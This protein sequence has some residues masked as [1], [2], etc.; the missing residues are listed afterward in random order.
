MQ[1]TPVSGGINNAYPSGQYDC[2]NAHYE[3]EWWNV[4]CN[5]CSSKKRGAKR[6]DGERGL[7]FIPLTVTSCR[8]NRTL[9]RGET[10]QHN[11]CAT[12]RT[13]T[14]LEKFLVLEDGG[15]RDLM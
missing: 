8:K 5:S 10:Y 13:I 1:G 6:E 4:Q 14:V 9:L 7:E 12:D 3:M 11:L 15:I 2:G